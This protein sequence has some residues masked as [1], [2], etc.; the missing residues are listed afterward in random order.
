MFY[1]LVSEINDV[2]YQ[3]DTLGYQAVYTVINGVMD[4]LNRN[5]PYY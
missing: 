4:Y 2:I 3:M 5:D 1:R